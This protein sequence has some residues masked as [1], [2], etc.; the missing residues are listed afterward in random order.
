[1]ND[2]VTVNRTTLRKVNESLEKTLNE[3]N[4]HLHPLDTIT[5]SCRSALKSLET[6]KGDIFGNDCVTGNLVSYKLKN[7]I[8]RMGREIPRDSRHLCNTTTCQRV[9]FRD[10]GETGCTFCFTSMANSPTFTKLTNFLHDY[11]CVTW[12]PG[13][14]YQKG[15]RKQDWDHRNACPWV[16]RKIVHM[17]LDVAFLHISAQS[18]LSH[19]DGI[20]VIKGVLSALRD[21]PSNP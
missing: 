17:P 5:S 7:S 18:L 13:V 11:D 16:V 20:E 8:T 9:L 1:M 21:T 19:V 6:A 10:T 12:S 2:S 15:H 4:C 14:K 3:P